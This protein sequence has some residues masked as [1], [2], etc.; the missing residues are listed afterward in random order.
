MSAVP[1]SWQ[2][3]LLM[4]GCLVITL[5]L[6]FVLGA[7]VYRRPIRL[8]QALLVTVILF[9]IWDIVAI[10]ANLWTYS[11]QFTTGVILPFGIPLEEVVFFVVIS[12]CGVLTY[13]AVGRVLS[14]FRSARRREPAATKEAED[15]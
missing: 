2:Y 1:D 13:E 9:T 6:E 4:A 8:L 5:P 12:L 10:R 7:R 14:F 3:L 15:A 11:E